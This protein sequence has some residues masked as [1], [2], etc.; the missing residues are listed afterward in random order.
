M[1][2]LSFHC[3]CYKAGALK[4]IDAHNRRLH[5]NHIIKKSSHKIRRSVISSLLDNLA[6]KKAVQ[7][8]AGHENIETTFNSYYKN[9]S[10][11][12][13]LITGMCACL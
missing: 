11:D 7:E 10:D 5:K 12:D 1:A 6:N 2:V 4:G 8:F 13:D 3:Q 9:I